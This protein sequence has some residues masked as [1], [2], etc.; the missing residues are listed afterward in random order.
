LATKVGSRQYGA[1]KRLNPWISTTPRKNTL[2]KRN[3]PQVHWGIMNRG[4]VGK[5]VLAVVVYVAITFG[6]LDALIHWW[7]MVF[8]PVPDAIAL[9][10]WFVLTVGYVW[11][12]LRTLR[13]P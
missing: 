2:R 12:A 3:L 1:S 4:K 9:S 10:L 6:V 11:L 5:I 7:A 8:S 13:K